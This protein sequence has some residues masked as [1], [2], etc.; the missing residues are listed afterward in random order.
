MVRSFYNHLLDNPEFQVSR[1]LLQRRQLDKIA[2]FC[3]FNHDEAIRHVADTRSYSAHT[4]I[5][6][7]AANGIIVHSDSSRNSIRRPLLGVAP[8]FPPMRGHGAEAPD[9]RQ[10]S[11]VDV[12]QH[13]SYSLITS[14]RGMQYHWSRRHCKLHWSLGCVPTW[15]RRPR[16]AGFPP[17][18]PLCAHFISP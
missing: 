8:S 12:L 14:R 13:L 1:G 7:V 15:A 3:S 9:H 18:L 11:D 4:I 2:T 16:F 10:A 6:I 17:S 5:P